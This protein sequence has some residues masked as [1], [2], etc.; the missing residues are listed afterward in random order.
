METTDSPELV[1]DIQNLDLWRDRFLLEDVNWRVRRGEHWAVLGR[2]GAGKTLLLRVVAGY[3]WPSRG[4]VRVLGEPFGQVD[5]RALRRDIG[6][7]S[8]ALS[9][10]IPGGDNCFEVVLSGRYATFGLYQRPSSEDEDRARWLLEDMGLAGLAEQAWRNLS[11]GEKQRVLLARGRMPRPRLL[12]LDEPCAGLDL[13]AREKLLALIEHI[14]HDPDGPTLLMVT[15][16]VEELT[17][18][19]SH[20]LMLHRGR[21]AARGPIRDRLTDANLSAVMELPV[22]VNFDRGRWSV[23]VEA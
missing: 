4:S 15:H 6:W 2:N 12:I 1:I 11:A 22:R 5:L 23:R 13:A 17:S 7:V 21:V 18:G 3:L 14:A 8:S 20:V 16:R 19:F 10:R 9:E